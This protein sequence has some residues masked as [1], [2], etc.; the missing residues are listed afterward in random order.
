MADK[1]KNDGVHPM[2]QL[3]ILAPMQ[4]AVPILTLA[5]FIFV[6]FINMAFEF[7]MEL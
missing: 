6:D 1:F 4:I 2:T 5:Y 7:D 3:R